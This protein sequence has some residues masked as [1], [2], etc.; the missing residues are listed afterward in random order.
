MSTLHFRCSFD[1]HAQESRD[2]WPIL[3]G[4]VRKWIAKRA[5]A[6]TDGTFKGPWFFKGDQWRHPTRRGIRVLTR[7]CYGDGTPENPN[8]WGAE[9]E[10]PCTDF[11]KWRF[12]RTH[13]GVEQYSP[14]DFRLTMQ[15]LH[16]LRDGY[17]GEPTAPSPSSPELIRRLLTSRFWRCTAGSE[18]LSAYPR[19]LR[20]GEGNLFERLLVSRERACPIVLVSQVHPNRGYAVSPTELAKQLAG[21]AIVFQSENS[22]VDEELDSL[23]GERFGCRKGAIRIYF[24]GLNVT[25]PR[26]S[27][28]HRY[29]PTTEIECSGPDKVIE[30]VVRC[31]ARGSRRPNEI[32]TPFDVENVSRRR[33]ID[34]LRTRQ[35][36]GAKDEWIQL[37]EKDNE[38]LNKEKTQLGNEITHLEEH[39]EELDDRIRRLEHERD[40]IKANL[41]RARGPGTDGENVKEIV[42]CLTKLPESLSDAV[43]KIA[44]IHS[45]R[46]AFTDRAVKSASEAEF[47]DISTAWRALWAMATTLYDV[48]FN[49]EGGNKQKAFRDQSGFELAMTEGKLTNQDKKLMSLRK[50]TFMGRAINITAHVKFD[51]ARTRAYFCPFQ[52]N[53]TK[54]IVVGHIGSH[55]DTAGTRRNG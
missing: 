22:E 26:E 14:T 43:E 45:R 10:H 34:H 48:F 53:G 29:I 30:R 20:V 27:E 2:A 24:T 19:D 50:D 54:L 35:D 47:N 52:E 11:P 12:W 32:L 46:I 1:L 25:R 33:Q 21:A 9:L 3:L 39:V 41:E 28:R 36:G 17:I 51:R 55:L 15:I 8:C 18:Q 13:I 37:L 6:D 42:D 40:S 23:L 7:A 44:R 49:E 5:N 4:T 38:T 31:L 16:D